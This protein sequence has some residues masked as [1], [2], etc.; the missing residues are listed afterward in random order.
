VIRTQI[1]IKEINREHKTNI[2]MELK[3]KGIKNK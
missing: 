3:R 2:E 1:K